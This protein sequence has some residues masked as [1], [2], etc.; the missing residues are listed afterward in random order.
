MTIDAFQKTQFIGDIIEIFEEFL[1]ERGIVIDN[2]EKQDAIDDGEDEASIANIYGTDYGN[3]EEE[4]EYL[5]NS[6]K[7][8]DYG[9]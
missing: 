8:I 7:I 6:W 2:P 3:L 1:E 4:L 9:F 5:L